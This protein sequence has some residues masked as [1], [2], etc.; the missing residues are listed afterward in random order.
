MEENKFRLCKLCINC[1]IYAIR[2][3]ALDFL[4]FLPT[5]TIS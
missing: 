2:P 3:V 4:E 1:S 5:S